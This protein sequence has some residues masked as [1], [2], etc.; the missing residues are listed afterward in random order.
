MNQGRVASDCNKV[1]Y[2]ET[3]NMDLTKGLLHINIDIME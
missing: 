1:L 2:G 3:D